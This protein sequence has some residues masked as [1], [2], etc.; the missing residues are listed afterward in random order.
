MVDIVDVANDRAMQEVTS[1]LSQVD[2]KPE[3]AE[4]GFCL[5]CG[6]CVDLG[7]RWCDSN[8]RD[9]WQYDQKRLS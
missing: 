8:C 6:K 1:K 3:A 9:D 7:Q 4:T 2:T 5:F